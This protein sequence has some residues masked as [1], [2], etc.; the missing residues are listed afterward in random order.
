V[1]LA[2]GGN[3]E[4]RRPSNM[5]FFRKR[6]TGEFFA[7]FD[8]KCFPFDFQSLPFHLEMSFLGTDKVR[9]VPSS[10]YDYTVFFNRG[11]C[12]LSS[13]LIRSVSSEY[14]NRGDFSRFEM[15]VS[16]ERN[17]MAYMNRVIIPV[18]LIS[19]A[20]ILVFAM[21]PEDSV[22][23]RLGLGI[24]LLLTM[25]A[26]EFT[27]A[28]DLPKDPELSILDKYVKGSFAFLL[29]VLL[30]CGIIGWH[31]HDETSAMTTSRKEL[32]SA[33]FWA[34]LIMWIT[35]QVYIVMAGLQSF[36]KT[37]RVLKSL[38]NV[39]QGV[40]GL[41]GEGVPV[42][43]VGVCLGL[44]GGC[45]SSNAGVAAPVMVLQSKHTVLKEA[46]HCKQVSYSVE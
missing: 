10:M 8:L 30:F 29:V 14:D 42:R 4:L 11:Y 27:L 36:W 46:R 44:M 7:P 15:A 3:Y 35:L 40:T 33:A 26:F 16:V 25:V 18:F 23:D 6:F 43:Q 24:T 41:V 20:V 37:G 13:Y 34:S 17:W 28:Q 38:S 45:A 31:G 19:G 9:L 39:V 2:H 1:P 12:V 22:A 21:A 32:D 5:V